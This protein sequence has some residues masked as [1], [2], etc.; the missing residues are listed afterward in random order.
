M[1]YGYRKI[2]INISHVHATHTFLKMYTYGAYNTHSV[3]I[4]CLDFV[5]MYLRDQPENEQDH[6][7]LSRGQTPVSPASYL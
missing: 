2:I 3:K 1:C 4:Y 6:A 5:I 7:R